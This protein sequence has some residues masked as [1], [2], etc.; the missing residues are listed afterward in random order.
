M[1]SYIP[2][3][4]FACT[5]PWAT[6]FYNREDAEGERGPHSST[7]INSSR[8]K[9]HQGKE[10]KNRESKYREAVGRREK[11]KESGHIYKRVCTKFKKKKKKHG[12]L[13]GQTGFPHP[14]QYFY[15]LFFFFFKEKTFLLCNISADGHGFLKRTCLRSST[16]HQHHG[17]GHRVPSD[18]S[19]A[20]SRWSSKSKNRCIKRIFIP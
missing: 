8:Y 9:S 5:E 11:L 17:A 13:S 16:K 14:K 1:L 12:H 2:F 3:S 18:A 10:L 7:R 20:S 15:N 4:K 6:V 19:T